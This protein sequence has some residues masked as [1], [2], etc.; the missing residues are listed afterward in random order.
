VQGKKQVSRIVLDTV[1]TG[2]DKDQT[3]NFNKG[4]EQ[5]PNREQVNLNPDT[6]TLLNDA[7]D[8]VSTLTTSDGEYVLDKAS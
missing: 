5:G 2:A 7:G 1:E 4:T 8:E 3:V 6:L